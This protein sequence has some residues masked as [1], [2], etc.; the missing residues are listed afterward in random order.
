MYLNHASILKLWSY[1]HSWPLR[2][3]P[4]NQKF[5]LQSDLNPK[6]YLSWRIFVLIIIIIIIIINYF[7]VFR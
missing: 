4:T 7:F 2:A 6:I 3:S 5:L 1:F